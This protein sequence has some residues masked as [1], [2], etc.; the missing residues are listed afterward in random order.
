LILLDGPMGTELEAR[1]LE[2]PSP[3]WSANGLSVAPELVRSIHRDH[4]TAG[5]DVLR[6]TTFPTRPRQ[7]GGRWEEL[8]RLAVSLA[9]SESGGR[10]V[11]GSLAPLE[12]C[13]RP[14]LSPSNPGPEHAELARVL[15]DAGCDL[16][17]CETF[18][19]VGEALAAVEA[20]V[21]TGLPTWVGF[22]TG[23][24]GALLDEAAIRSG[25]RE[26]RARGASA[27]LLACSLADDVDRLLGALEGGRFG[28]YAN[29]GPPELGLGWGTSAAE[30][31]RSAER[32]AERARRWVARGA[33]IVGA[34][35]GGSPEHVRALRSAL[36]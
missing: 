26:A 35:C 28:A 8:A 17:V 31:T 22:T 16:L 3:A 9:K 7:V 4:V 1:G 18:P 23:P 36:G 20:C 15:A 5:C 10:P 21:A 24:D 12:D 25:A 13:Y 33:E 11:A 14:D 19:H 32:Y 30:R 2:L 27:V 6:T 34:C 29:A